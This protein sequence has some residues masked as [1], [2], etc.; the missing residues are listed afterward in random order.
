MAPDV[1]FRPIAS[2]SFS[3]IPTRSARA[4]LDQESWAQLLGLLQPESPP[5]PVNFS[6]EMVILLTLDERPTAGY[7]VA[8]D[9]IVQQET[10]LEVA[11]VEETPHPSCIVA[12]V[13]TRPFLAIAVTRSNRFV[14]A[15]W[16]QRVGPPCG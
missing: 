4:I 5:S 2:G 6:A 10:R 8:V 14:E 1:I 9:R 7:R 12:Q 11:A 15:Q 13:I 3:S 16:S